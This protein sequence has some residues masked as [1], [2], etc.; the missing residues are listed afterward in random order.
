MAG[1]DT[2]NQ[3]D[4]DEL[5][6]AEAGPGTDDDQSDIWDEMDAADPGASEP[7]EASPDEGHADDEEDGDQGN[8]GTAVVAEPN[9]ER[10]TAPVEAQPSGRDRDS[11]EWASAPPELKPRIQK[12]AEER[13][14]IGQENHRNRQQ[15]GQLKAELAELR[16]QVSPHTG[17]TGADAQR[18]AD[19]SYLESDEAKR[20]REEYP[21]IASPLL[22]VIGTLESKLNGIERHVQTDVRRQEVAAVAE[23]E[24]LLR[25]THPDYLDVVSKNVDKYVSW[26]ETQPRHIR[27]AAQRNARD[28]V[29]ASEAADV[30][31]RFKASLGEQGEARTVTKE[32]TPPSGKRQ[33]Q[34]ISA[35][36]PQSR[37]PATTAEIPEDGD[38][39][40]LWDAM[41][42]EE[43]RKSARR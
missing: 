5:L 18:A 7:T 2:Q 34:L 35:I 38:P 37:G 25:E 1:R 4:D 36:A 14:L 21:E 15:I 16:R 28:I 17:A 8:A 9:H 26:L 19:G 43:A 3:I 29:D 40:A 12:L 33:R 10:D 30:V 24:V 32:A 20:F 11:D 22:K 27:E 23:Q 39:D 6:P 42:R 31:S 41:D 13:K